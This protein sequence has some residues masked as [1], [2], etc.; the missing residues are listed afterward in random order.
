[1]GGR[2]ELSMDRN[3]C[4]WSG[5]AMHEAIH[6]LGY[7]HMHNHV[8]RD[9]FVRIAWNNVHPDF[10]FAFDKV[11]PRW[12]S[13]F[14]TPYDLM[15]VMHYPRWAF[16]MNGQDTIIPHDLRFINSLGVSGLSSGDIM[17]INRMYSCPN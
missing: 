11:D 1:M 13:N 7:D 5:T 3:G 16:S 14:N 2:Q 4:F 10:R 15:S 9:S 17:R 6:A 12:F 8:D